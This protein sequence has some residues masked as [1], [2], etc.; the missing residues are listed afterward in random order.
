MAFENVELEHQNISFG[1]DSGRIYSFDHENNSLVVKTFPG[2]S[3]VAIAPLDT[4]IQNEVISLEYDGYYFWTLSRLGLNGDLGARIEKWFYDGTTVEK[5]LGTGNDVSLINGGAITYDTE[6]MCVQTFTTTLS[7]TVTSG[8]TSFTVDDAS[9]LNIGDSIYLGPSN[10]QAGEREAK[11]VVSVLGNVVTV[12]SPLQN[13]FLANDQVR[14]LKNI[15]L[16]NNSNGTDTSGGSLLELSTS[17]GSVVG[18]RSGA[19]WRSVTAATVKNNGDFLFARNT[20]LLTYRPFGLNSGFQS[21][22]IMVNVHPNKQDII[23]VFDLASDSTSFLKL[24]EELVYFD[25]PSGEYLFTTWTTFNVDQE[26]FANRVFSLK[27]REMSSLVWVIENTLLA[28]N[29]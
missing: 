15:W 3:P 29:S 12:N 5:Q 11:T 14:Y 9:F 1:P 23:K 25:Q 16:F 26:F 18:I 22:L 6:A 13:S 7:F 2:G 21:S 8:N 24:Q 27:R 19:Q 10:F 4:P 20:Q 17:I 28:K